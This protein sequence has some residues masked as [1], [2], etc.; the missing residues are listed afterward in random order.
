LSIKKVLVFSDLH[1][2]SRALED[3]I[4]V[5]KD[6]NLSIFCGDILGY[7]KDIDYCIDFV[8]KNIDLVVL[9]NHERLAVSEEDLG[10]QIPA[11]QK[12]ALY[13]RSKLTSKQRDLLISLPVEIWYEDLY[14]THSIT[15]EYLRTDAGFEKIFKK[16]REDTRYAFFGHTHEQV[17]ISRNNKTIINPGSITKGRRGLQRGYVLM[18]SGDVA[19]VRLEPII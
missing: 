3:I 9:G 4:P 16:M 12:S 15:D 2:N 17:L 1:A 14:I 8:L 18:N 5:L 6:V 11:V 19:F 10:S 13:A 7:G